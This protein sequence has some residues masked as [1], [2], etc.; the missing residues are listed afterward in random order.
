VFLDRGSERVRLDQ[1]IDG[2]RAGG[3]GVVLLRGEAGIGKTALLELAVESASDLLVLRAAGVESEMELPYAALHQLCAPT[4][5][6]LDRLPGPQRDA[7]AVTFGL[8]EG[9]AA[10]RFF[11]SLAL[12]SLLSEVAEE[13]PLLCAVDDAQWLDQSSARALAFVARRLVAESVVMVFAAREPSDELRGLPELLVEGLSD[14]DARE[15]L[16]AAIPW[17][18]DELVYEQLVA[19]TRGNPLALIEL[20]RVSPAQLA[21]GLGL[22]GALSLEGRIRESFHGRAAAL[23]PESQRLLLLAAAE[24]T[25]DPALLS[26]A[27]ERMGLAGSA[28]QPAEVAGLVEVGPRVR[29]RHPLVRSAVYQGASLEERRAVHGALAEATDAEDDPYRRAWHLAEATAGAD[30]A[31]ATELER[32]AARAE[33]LGGLPAAAAFLERA[34][35]LTADPAARSE[36]ALAAAQ[37]K[38]QAGI[39]DV[40]QG[41][42]ATA[43]TGP[44]GE[45]QLARAD[46]VRAQLA[47][48]TSRGSHASPLL[49]NAAR[50]LEP[51]APEMARATYL[52]AMSAAIF[53]GRL[54]AP[55]GSAEDV[56]GAA[57]AAPQRG[58][59]P[60]DLFL[61]GL[62]ANFSEGYTAGLPI[63]RRALR[64]FADTIGG[65]QHLRWVSLAFL[66]SFHTWDDRG[67]AMIS[68]RWVRLCRE[69]G[70]LSELPLALSS[71]A[72]L[73]LLTGE[74]N[75][76]ASLVEELRAATEA[77]GIVFGPYA[78]MGLA[79]YRG[80]EAG[81]TA[82]IEATIADA[83][84][85]G[86]GNCLSAAEWASAVLSNGLGHYDRAL[87]AA[88]RASEGRW[89]IVFTSW[90]LSE[91]IE[92]AARSG[93]REKADAACRR[94]AEMSAATGTD[95][96]RGIEARSR[97]LLTDGGAAETLY[98]EAIERLGR[99][100]VRL[101]LA[102]A[103]LLYGEWLRRDR[104]RTDA[105]EQ[106]R[107]A[108]EMFVAMGVG[109]FAGRAEQ[110][111]LA[112][113]ERVR[114]RSVETRE[115]L[116]AQ[117]AEIARLARDGVPNAEIGLRLFISRRTV[118]YHLSKV[119]T[120]L[121]ISSRHELD[122]VLPSEP[123]A[124]LA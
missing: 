84:L 120:K 93:L 42:L 67:S 80:E 73:L 35:I 115:E 72:L 40:V 122:L 23:Q 48:V 62:A 7:L 82:L 31:V 29:F 56:A 94:L 108:R 9:A 74:L 12:L 17:T 5:D 63:L 64:S 30:E 2:A 116:T 25:G 18:L 79:A 47:F 51:I 102:R 75:G 44:L 32:S 28:L 43:E 34:A 46:L 87:A 103:H 45:P 114:K 4:L 123:T 36:R 21:G 68:E 124:A 110:E 8:K 58:A 81:A 96:V 91:L 19:E 33:A 54:A 39:L 104:R 107:N 112:T 57:S 22:P 49:L 111:L 100:R 117:E 38:V 71:R 16:T 55:G 92:G 83:S 6:R 65:D 10:D 109:G 78:A 3:S 50:R 14:A 20:T 90:A 118:E 86:E 98:R 53:A 88:E 15:L 59:S 99:T 105:R 85:R 60:A 76:V 119:F 77:A 37:T 61:D 41:L 27:A 70:S 26:R 66:A 24:P 95:W 1:L 106:L 101:E 113:G 89:E 11:V 52:D 97:A 69:A 121:G 13:R